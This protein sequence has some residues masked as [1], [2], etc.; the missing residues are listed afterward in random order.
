[1]DERKNRDAFFMR[2]LKTNTSPGQFNDFSSQDKLKSGFIV[3]IAKISMRSTYKK[4]PLWC[5][6][7]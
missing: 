4:L 2:N 7:I 6:H 3:D 1:M 5:S